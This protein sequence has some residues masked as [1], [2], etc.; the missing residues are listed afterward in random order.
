MNKKMWGVMVYLSS[1]QWS[2]EKDVN[3][4]KCESLEFDDD[5]WEY[6]LDESEKI[7]INTILL[8]VGD[9]IKYEKHPEIS[10]KDAWPRE[11]VAMELKRCREKGITIIPKVNF[12]STHCFWLG[13]YRRMMSTN[14]YYR[15]C[16]D[17]IQE[18]YEAFEQ[19]EY[20]H[21]GMDEE[22]AEFSKN[23]GIAMYRQGELFWH[24]LKFLLDCVNETGAKPWI[25][26]SPLF[27]MPEEYKAHIGADEAVISPYYY[28]ALNK[29]FYTRTDSRPEYVDYYIKEGG[30][31][32]H[33]KLE[34]VEHD[35]FHTNFRKMA[36]PLM[37]DGYKYIPCPSVFNHCDRN[38]HDMLEYFK[39]NAPDEQIIGYLTAP[40]Y[41]TTWK[42]KEQFDDTFRF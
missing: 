29:K 35:P 19:P 8:D 5:F 41:D 16:K 21:I 4:K 30:Q 40:W 17:V 9:G 33:L 27:D 37:K 14:T 38:T 7:G 20:I 22:N 23:H 12:A 39:T 28:H 10:L 1:N 32:S 25:W 11:R 3:V 31:C 13:E 6:I 26:H 24:D 42:N 36:L 34:Y 18:V 2:V 15:V